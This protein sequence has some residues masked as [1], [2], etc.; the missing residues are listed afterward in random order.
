MGN[1][2]RIRAEEIFDINK[3]V[4]K[5]MKIYEDLSNRVLA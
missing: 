4:Q 2:G 1:A 5:H 3:V